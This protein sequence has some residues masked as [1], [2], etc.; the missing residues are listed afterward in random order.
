MPEL[1]TPSPAELYDEVIALFRADKDV[2]QARMFGASGLSV[3][4]KTFAMLHRGE[5]VVKLDPARC[6]GLVDGGVARFFDPGHGRLMKAWV[7]IGVGQ[8]SL[9]TSLATEAKAYVAGLPNEKK[10]RR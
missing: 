5:L 3:A 7:G 4:R 8:S 2:E 6:K 10:G 1:Q 9:W